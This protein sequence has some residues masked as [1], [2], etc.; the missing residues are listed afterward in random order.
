MNAYPPIRA[1]SFDL[2]DTLW[3]IWSVI[4]RAECELHAWL[5]RHHPEIPAAFDAQALRELCRE[6]AVTRPDLAHDRSALRRGALRLAAERVGVAPFCEH[7]AFEVFNRVRNEVQFFPDALP[8]LHRLQ[9]RYPLIA[10]SNGNADLER[11]GIDHLFSLALNPTVTGTAKPEPAIF[12]AA[13]EHLSLRPDEVVHVGDDPQL[14]VIGAARAGMRT[15]WINRN[16][17]AWPGGPVADAEVR[18]LSELHDV[19]QT[20]EASV[21]SAAEGSDGN[22]LR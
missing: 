18:S 10:L 17:A 4:A 11:I 19:L 2:D 14:D 1:L 9:A 3:D 7:T 15:V 20:W 16:G 21:H 6:V 22:D 5:E 13:C 8:A 12:L